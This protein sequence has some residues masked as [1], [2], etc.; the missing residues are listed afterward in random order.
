M[1]RHILPVAIAVPVV[2]GWLLL[3]GE[4]AGWY[5]H[6]LQTALLALLTVIILGTLLWHTA[7]WL[8]R[9][10]EEHHRIERT[11]DAEEHLLRTLMD[12]VPAHI[13]FKD[14]AVGFS[15]SVGRWLRS[16]G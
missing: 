4:R 7:K 2:L 5:D 16:S 13:Y 15:G 3:R 12:N 1:I 9:N 6:V 11:L 8:N 14:G 10:E